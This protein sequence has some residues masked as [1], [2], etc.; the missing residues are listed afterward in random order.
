MLGENWEI[1]IGREK[2]KHS[3]RGQ[4]LEQRLGN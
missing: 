2:G 4:Q 1:G 3:S